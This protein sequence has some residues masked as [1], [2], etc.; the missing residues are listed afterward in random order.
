MTEDTKWH[1]ACT[2]LDFKIHYSHYF[3]LCTTFFTVLLLVQQFQIATYLTLEIEIMF[4]LLG[5]ICF[6]EKNVINS[7]SGGCCNV[8]LDHHTE[9]HYQSAKTKKGP[10]DI[11]NKNPDIFSHRRLPHRQQKP[12][13]RG[14]RFRLTAVTQKQSKYSP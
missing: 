4:T 7:S 3:S 1:T 11:T 12:E 8:V 9:K 2:V 10:H 13:G 14:R 5:T 6:L